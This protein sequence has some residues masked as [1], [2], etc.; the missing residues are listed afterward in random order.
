[1]VWKAEYHLKNVF[2]RQVKQTKNNDD[3]EYTILALLSER[4]L[5]TLQR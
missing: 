2:L 4:K 1:M 5:S 3:H